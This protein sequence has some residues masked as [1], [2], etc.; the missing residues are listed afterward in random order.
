MINKIGKFLLNLKDHAVTPDTL[1]IAIDKDTAPLVI[2]IV[3]NP[4]SEFIEVIA[5]NAHI[6]TSEPI[7]GFKLAYDDIRYPPGGAM[8]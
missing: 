2:T 8:V 5:S 1:E 6:Y 7:A 4:D 3:D